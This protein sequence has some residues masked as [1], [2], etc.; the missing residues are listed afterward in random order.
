MPEP[1]ASDAARELYDSLSPAST[2]G[3]EDR[4]W[5]ALKLCM[6]LS[7]GPLSQIY[8]YVIPAPGG[9]GWEIVLDPAN[10]PVEVL[11]W[12][13]QFDGAVLKPEMSEAER[14]AA[15]TSPQAFGRGTLAAIEETIKRRL[16]GTKTVIITERYTANPWRVRIETLEAETPDQAAIEE[17]L[18]REQKPIGILFFFNERVVWTWKEMREEVEWNTWAKVQEKG[19]TWLD[20]RT[21]EP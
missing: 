19:A 12:L 10:A 7:A 18:R 6:G 17:D 21:H 16:T 4:D 5:V 13:A 8:T 11:E 14:R 1:E 15:I 20:V 3:H 9:V 2:T